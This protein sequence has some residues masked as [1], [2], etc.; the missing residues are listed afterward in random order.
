MFD[1]RSSKN[2]I[3]N[4]PAYIIA[5]VDVYDWDA[6]REYMK[7]TPRVVSQYGGRFIARGASPTTL[8]GQKEELRVVI[9]E[10]PS[11]E[12]AKAFYNS[13]EYSDTKKIREGGASAQ[14]IAVNG[15]PIE[16]WNQA[17]ENSNKLAD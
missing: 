9:M 14:F 3:M 7:H 15:Y 6:Y 2:K 12:N 4:T 17:V 11:I 5:R 13:Q 1:P 8:E 10:F 16:E